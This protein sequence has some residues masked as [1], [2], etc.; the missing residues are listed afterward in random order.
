MI[1]SEFRHMMLISLLAQQPMLLPDHLPQPRRALVRLA[2]QAT[3][4]SWPKHPGE[5]RIGNPA[6]GYGI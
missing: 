3:R 6:H 4:R 5:A 1:R 2:E